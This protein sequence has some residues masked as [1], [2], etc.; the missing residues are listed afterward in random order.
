MCACICVGECAGMCACMCMCTCMSPPSHR[1]P[2]LR[3]HGRR[4]RQ[5]RLEELRV[6]MVK[7]EQTDEEYVLRREKDLDKSRRESVRLKRLEEQK[8]AYAHRLQARSP[9]AVLRGAAAVGAA[10]TRRWW[11]CIR[12]VFHCCAAAGM[13]RRRAVVLLCVRWLRRPRGWCAAVAAAAAVLLLRCCP[14]DGA[15]VCCG[16]AVCCGAG[17]Q[18]SLARA[19]APVKKKSGKP[20]MFRSAPLKAVVKTEEVDPAREQ[21][22]RDLKFLT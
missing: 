9:R 6:A 2:S 15:V 11:W 5:A 10:R 13:M 20:V 16:A 7:L 3:V 1:L 22:L 17:V 21:E 12:V 8:E 18:V 14:R 4:P 19:Q